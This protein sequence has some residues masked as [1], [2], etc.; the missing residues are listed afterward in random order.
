MT[1]QTRKDPKDPRDTFI[2]DLK[3]RQKNYVWPD[4]QAQLSPSTIT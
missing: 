4:I 3:G 1:R 2:R